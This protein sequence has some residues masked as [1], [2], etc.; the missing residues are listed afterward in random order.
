MNTS[1]GGPG[2][3]LSPEEREACR[4][5]IDSAFPYVSRPQVGEGSARDRLVQQVRGMLLGLAIRDALGRSTEGQAPG[6]GASGSAKSGTTSICNGTGWGRPPSVYLRT[7]PSS[8]SLPWNRFFVRDGWIRPTWLARSRGSASTVS[9]VL[10]GRSCAPTGT[11]VSRGGKRG[12]PA[13]GMA[14]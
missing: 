11:R 8:L 4:P 12:S 13:R 7:T 2:P 10:C 14:P 3:Q 5:W 9:G 1:A 6:A